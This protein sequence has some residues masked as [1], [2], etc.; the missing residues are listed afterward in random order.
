TI[1]PGIGLHRRAVYQVDRIADGQKPALVSELVERAEDGQPLVLRCRRDLP[2]VAATWQARAG[3]GLRV[4]GQ[5][6]AD[7]RFA[8]ASARNPG[9]VEALALEQLAERQDRLAVS[10]AGFLALG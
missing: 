9:K 10:R 1:R 5:T 3:K 2:L 4:E 7:L 8:F 6:L